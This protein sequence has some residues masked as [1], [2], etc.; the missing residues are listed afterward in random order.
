MYTFLI[1][2]HLLVSILLIAVVLLQSGKSADLAGAFGGYGSQSSFGPRGMATFMSKFTTVLAVLFMVI[3]LLLMIISKNSIDET[4]TKSGAA[5][6]Q[7]NVLVLDADSKKPV[8]GA[9]VK[10]YQGAKT[11][12]DSKD[13]EAQ[14]TKKAV[15]EYNKKT[16]NEKG[17]AAIDSVVAK[18]QIFFTVEA[19]GYKTLTNFQISDFTKGQNIE[20]RIKKLESDKKEVK[21]PVEKKVEEIK[22]NTEKKVEETKKEEVKKEEVKTDSNKKEESKEV[23]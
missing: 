22:V 6:N 9:L 21:T 8:S 23:K 5:I 14:D 10:Y 13:K 16:S 12:F 11:S 17:I 18:K 15:S 20:L 19:K 7:Y 2:L 4:S 3:T 1:I